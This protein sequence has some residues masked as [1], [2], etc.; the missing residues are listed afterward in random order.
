MKRM[1]KR[2]AKERIWENQRKEG[3]N[4]DREESEEVGENRRECWSEW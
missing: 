1:G 3:I 4:W 2:L